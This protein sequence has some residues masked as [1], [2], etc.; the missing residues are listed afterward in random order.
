[1]RAVIFD[2]WDTLVEWPLDEAARLRE[3]MAALV[4][5]ADD[6]SCGAGRRCYRASQTGPLADALPDARR[7]PR[8]G[9]R[10]EVAASPRVRPAGVAAE[11]GRD[12]ASWRMRAAA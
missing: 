4:G 10:A 7:T 12:D 2:L 5:V 1:M 6:E 11:A 3:R 8:A 9:W